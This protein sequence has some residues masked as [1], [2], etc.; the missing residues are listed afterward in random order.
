M[1]KKSIRH[2]EFWSHQ[3]RIKFGLPLLS[4]L[5][6]IFP[7]F[8]K[9][10][11]ILNVAIMAGIYVILASSMNIT[12]GYAGVFSMG[13]SAFYGIGA[14][15]TGI[16][17]YHFHTGFWAG[18]VVAGVAAVIFGLLLGIPTLRL[19]GIFFAFVTVSFLEILRLVTM[20]W[21]SI[22]RG[23]M[24]IP[25]IPAP[26]IFGWSLS[27]NLHYYY[28]ILVMDILTIFCIYRAVHSRIGR[29]LMAI[30]D[31]D[32]AASTL[33]IPTFQYRL[34][35][36]SFS[37]F[38][39]GLAGCFYAH[40]ATYISADSFGVS[41][42]FIIMTMMVVGGMGTISGPIIGAILLVVFPEV[43]RFLLEYRMVAY[44]ALLIFM[45]LF[46][47]EGLLGLPGISGTEG[48]LSKLRTKA[49]S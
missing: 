19:K 10:Q 42:T 20:N 48:V 46:R 43:F 23:P 47:P 5:L 16:L 40:Y 13:H 36:L 15:A 39:C 4:G 18:L 14:Y 2:A 12:N 27:S 49:A 1:S 7:L 35:A 38:F 17:T 31:D 22:T 34:L 21:I 33:G 30:R 6:I 37:T 41:E 28:L 11:Y 8:V 9:N 3:N 26:T 32:L 44:G 29:A 24:G 45:I 25:G